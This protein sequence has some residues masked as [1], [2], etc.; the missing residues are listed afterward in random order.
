MEKNINHSILLTR[1]FATLFILLC[2]IGTAINS[3]LIAQTFSVG[4][5]IFFKTVLYMVIY[6]SAI[7]S[8]SC[9]YS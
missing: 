6:V 5:Q 1:I 7:F 2:H 4:V 8:V 3:S 9:L